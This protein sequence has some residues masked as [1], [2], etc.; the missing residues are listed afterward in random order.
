MH[1]NFKL[2]VID[3]DSIC[4]LP[5]LIQKNTK[6]NPSKNSTEHS[7]ELCDFLQNC[8]GLFFVGYGFQ[9]IVNIEITKFYFTNFWAKLL[10]SSLRL[11][12]TLAQAG[13]DVK[14]NK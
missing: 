2:L 6:S 11:K 10:S 8:Q 7:M 12:A 3:A 1:F 14:P 9:E 13:E 5:V 4:D